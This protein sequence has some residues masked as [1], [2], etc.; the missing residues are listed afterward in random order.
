MNNLLTYNKKYSRSEYAVVL[1]H[2]ETLCVDLVHLISCFFSF[3]ESN[4]FSWFKNSCEKV[5]DV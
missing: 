3:P 4:M 5:T 2:Y 1:S